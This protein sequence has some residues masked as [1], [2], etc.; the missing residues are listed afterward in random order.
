MAGIE[1]REP[2]RHLAR[3][4]E[5][6]APSMFGLNLPSPAAEKQSDVA[7]GTCLSR[8]SDHTPPTRD[9]SSSRREIDQDLFAFRPLRHEE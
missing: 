3:A 8:Q 9:E 6:C 1:G 5:T 7:G 2:G 4:R